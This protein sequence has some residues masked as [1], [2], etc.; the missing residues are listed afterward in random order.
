VPAKR[1]YSQSEGALI[2]E[3]QARSLRRRSE[4]GLLQ[5][6]RQM[7]PC[8]RW[9]ASSIC[10]NLSFLTHKP[11]IIAMPEGHPLAGESR[12]RVALL[13]DEPLIASS[14]ELE[15][16]FGGDAAEGKFVNRAPDI[17]TILCLFA[18]GMGCAFVSASFRRVAMP[19]IAYRELAGPERNAAGGRPPQRQSGAGNESFH[20]HPESD[21]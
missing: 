5:Q 12:I 11:F 2:P 7:W 21:A 19:G 4:S 1:R 20:A 8:D 9:A 10:S 3:Q 18:A 17:L 15:L 6:R 13:A 16:G 14:V